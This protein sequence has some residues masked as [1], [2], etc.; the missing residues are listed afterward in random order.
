MLL[1]GKIREGC[2]VA[3]LDMVTIIMKHYA[4]VTEKSD[5]GGRR[6]WSDGRG[7][8]GGGSR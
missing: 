1:G 6:L 2:G 4:I 5:A 3:V 8:S 7:N